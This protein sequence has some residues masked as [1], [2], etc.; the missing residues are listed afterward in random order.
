VIEAKHLRDSLLDTVP[1]LVWT[2]G[3]DGE[4]D[5]VNARWRDYTGLPNEEGLGWH[6]LRVVHPDDA[7]IARAALKQAIARGIPLDVQLRFRRADGVY[8]W[9]VARAVPA[10]QADGRSLW[11]GST[12][13]VDRQKRVERML[14]L[15]ENANDVLAASLD[16]VDALG[17]VCELPVPEI[18]DWCFVVRSA[19]VV[20]ARHGL[21]GARLDEVSARAREVLQT[22][23]PLIERTVAIFP[24]I[25]GREVVGAIAF[26]IEE[27]NRS[28][29]GFHV[30]FGTL[31]AQHTATAILNAERYEREH[32]A[33]QILQHALLPS[34]LPEVDG[35]R[36]EAC[37]VAAESAHNV[38]GDWYDAFVLDDRRLLVSIGDV[39][40]T[41]LAA[42][43]AMGRVR[44]WLRTAGLCV[45]DPAG[46]LAVADDVLRDQSPAFVTCFVG[47]LDLPTR[48]MRYASAGHYPPCLRFADGTT[49]ELH[50][51]GLPLGVRWAS[52]EQRPV[53]TVSLQ[54]GSLLVMFTDGLIE[55]TRDIFAGMERFQR[56]LHRLHHEGSALALRDSLVE[57]PSTDDVAIL[58]IYSEP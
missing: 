8:R 11:I 3:A 49:Q 20:V 2:A 5:Y 38:G 39:A 9:H 40:G 14:E 29:K 28:F 19:G 33:A 18:A 10:R 42:A 53:G 55:Q 35:F 15:L 6:W 32:D 1:A 21:E 16:L 36:L 56:M 26:G 51:R 48:V 25:A 7:E 52:H 17:R 24:M 34:A 41:S 45:D 43:A 22:G 30:Q 31:L 58:T 44:D 12:F 4:I 37:Y 54:P 47:I 46:I 50:G 57:S 23:T 13:D 27:G